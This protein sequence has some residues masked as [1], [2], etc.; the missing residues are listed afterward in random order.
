[1]ANGGLEGMK[2][3]V[4]SSSIFPLPPAGYSGLEQLAYLCAKGLVERGHQVTLI[5]P[6]GSSCPGVELIQCLPPRF[7][8]EMV[9]GGCVWKDANGQDVQ[10]PGYWS[11][12]LEFNNGGV[13]IDHS[14]ETWSAALKMEGRLKAPVLRWCHAPVN[15]MFSQT[16]PDCVSCVCISDD[17]KQHLEALFYPKKAR[18]CHNGIDLDFYKPIQTKRTDRFLFLARFSSIKGPD[19]AIEACLKAG[20]GLDLIGDTTITQEPQLLQKCKEMADGKQIRI[21]GNVPR[22]E[23]VWWYSQAYALL[24]PNERFREPFGLAPVEALACECPV[25]AWDNGAMRETIRHGETGWL[26]HSVDELVERI[27]YVAGNRENSAIRAKC[28]EQA[29]KFSIQNMITR[30]E[31]LCEEALWKPW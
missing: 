25:L 22:G 14:W 13:I 19:I 10:W 9:Y 11:K 27:K 30:Y 31:E 23:T 3:C 7:P 15:S 1:M 2:I 20:V 8:E 26:V 5:A 28:R 6:I 17:Q 29:H 16:P 4:I 21:I 12:L 24:H 18:T